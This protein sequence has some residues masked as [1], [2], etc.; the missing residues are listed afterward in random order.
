MY[1]QLLVFK[2]NRPHFVISLYYFQSLANC[3][4]YYCLNNYLFL[5]N[6]GGDRIIIDIQCRWKF[7]FTWYNIKRDVTLI[8]NIP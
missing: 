7:S 8:I 6:K 4:K 1:V 2:I 3:L 5:W